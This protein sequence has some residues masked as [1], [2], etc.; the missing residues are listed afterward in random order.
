MGILGSCVQRGV[1][2]KRFIGSPP[3]YLSVQKLCEQHLKMDL[4]S[5]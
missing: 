5:S 4:T 2:D 1:D 3:N